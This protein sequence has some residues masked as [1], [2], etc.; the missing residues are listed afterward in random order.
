VCV[1]VLCWVVL[2]GSCVCCT[3]VVVVF[4][5]DGIKK[6]ILAQ[7]GL[8]SGKTIQIAFNLVF[9][10]D[11]SGVTKRFFEGTVYSESATSLSVD[12]GSVSVDAYGASGVVR[13]LCAPDF[14]NTLWEVVGWNQGAAL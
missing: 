3:P 12:L 10:T 2:L 14:M 13:D 4:G 1:C 7:G 6:K 5:V 11:D 9:E 8:K